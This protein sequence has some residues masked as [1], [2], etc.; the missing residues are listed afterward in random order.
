MVWRHIF[1]SLLRKFRLKLEIY[2]EWY[3]FCLTKASLSS[4]TANTKESFQMVKSME[5]EDTNLTQNWYTKDSTIMGKGK[6]KES[7]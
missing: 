3:Y 1:V 5:R 7:W 2:W 4:H 6:G